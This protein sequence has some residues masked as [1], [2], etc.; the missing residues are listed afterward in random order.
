MPLLL[1]QTLFSLGLGLLLGTLNVFFR[2]VGQ[3]VTVLL[4]FWFWLTPIVYTVDIVPARFQHWLL[5][6]PLQPIIAGYQSIFL[7]QSWPDFSSLVTPTLAALGCLVLG[8]W[9]FLRHADELVDEL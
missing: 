3:F 2:D 1:L 6:N 5:L 9:I 7:A 8:V 4:Q